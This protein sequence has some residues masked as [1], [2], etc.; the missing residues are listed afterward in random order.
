MGHASVLEHPELR[1]I[2][3]RVAWL[4]GG[5]FGFE[6]AV[7]LIIGSVALFADSIDF[8]EDASTNL[9][10]ILSLS[11]SLRRRIQVGY[12]LAGFLVLPSIA[13][14]WAIVE[15]L[16]HPAAPAALPLTLTGVAALVVNM[17]CAW[18]LARFRHAESSLTRAAFL[19]ARNDALANVAI[20][21]TG[22]LTLLYVSPWPDLA[23]GLGIAILNG[24]A[25]W[26]VYG[27]ARAEKLAASQSQA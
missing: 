5:F 4:N 22:L 17:Y 1:P 13:A 21:A 7:A 16:L 11:W 26:E 6:F 8:L 3:A 20:I 9:L 18:Q 15:K 25:A 24:K 12:C 2:L 19:C 14:G 27:L 10:I 23:V